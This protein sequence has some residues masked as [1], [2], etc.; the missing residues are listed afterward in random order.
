M[1]MFPSFGFK[2]PTNESPASP[3]QPTSN[4][5]SLEANGDWRRDY[6]RQYSDTRRSQ[7]RAG[8]WKRVVESVHDIDPR[9]Y[10]F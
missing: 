10:F 3:K 9:R 2:P 1:V 5:P 8:H 7:A 4:R 6:F